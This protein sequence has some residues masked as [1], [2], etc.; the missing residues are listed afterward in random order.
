MGSQRVR[1]DLATKRQQLGKE[2]E[3][4][5]GWVKITDILMVVLIW[6]FHK[7]ALYVKTS[8]T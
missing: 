8:D 7:L 4:S 2:N 3:T 6:I 1:H 5:M